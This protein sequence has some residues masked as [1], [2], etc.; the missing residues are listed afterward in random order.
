MM[1][2]CAPIQ[3]VHARR[4]PQRRG[5]TLIETAL[6]TIIVGVGVLAMIAA[7]QAFHQKNSWST[8]AST[9]TWLANEIREMTLTLPRHDPVTGTTTW[10]PE[11][12]EASIEDFDDIDD[13][14]G[15]T[16]EGIIFAADLGN[17]PINAQRKI[18]PNM[19][20]WSQTVRVYNVEP[21]NITADP[22]ESLDG[23]T[24]MVM[25]E[26]VVEYQ[27]PDDADPWEVIRMQWI[28]P[29]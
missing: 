16:G 7:Q 15:T 13:F 27:G 28:C 29:N 23:L 14:D 18:I 10:G 17:G 5:F 24:S 6:A 1:T 12:N 26:V 19:A 9:A 3:T 8:H 25:I 21:D 11:G 22:N 20:G 2:T 4:S